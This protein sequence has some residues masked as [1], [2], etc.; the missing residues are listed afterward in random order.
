MT[1]QVKKLYQNRYIDLRSYQIETA[2]KNN[3]PIVVLHNGEQMTLSVADLK[4]K[5][6]LLNKTPIQSKVNLD[7]TYLLYSFLWRA[8]KKLTEDEKLEQLVKQ[9]VC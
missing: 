5:K 4:T 6:L 7:Q 3:E 8:D 2:I 9:V 1:I